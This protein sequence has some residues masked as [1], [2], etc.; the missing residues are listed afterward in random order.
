MLLDNY[1]HMVRL[2]KEKNDLMHQLILAIIQEKVK[3]HDE[4]KRIFIYTLKRIP[5]INEPDKLEQFFVDFFSY[6][7]IR[8]QDP[9]GTSVLLYRKKKF[10]KPFTN[11]VKEILW[12]D[13]EYKKQKDS[14]NTTQEG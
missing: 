2:N 7:E 4:E 1:V 13:S 12:D 11:A 5:F 9:Y 8:V 10:S 14:L 3:G 6:K